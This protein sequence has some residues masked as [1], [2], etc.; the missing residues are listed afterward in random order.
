MSSR[1][2]ITCIEES[3]EV[4]NC[5]YIEQSIRCDEL[6]DIRKSRR[7]NEQELELEE[8]IRERNRWK[9]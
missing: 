4:L 5:E 7:T 3:M 9:W 2:Q 6:M 8:C 1:D